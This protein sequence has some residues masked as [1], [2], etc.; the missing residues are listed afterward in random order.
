MS[1]IFVHEGSLAHT[2]SELN[3]IL[4]ALSQLNPSVQRVQSQFVHLIHISETLTK[5]ELEVVKTLLTYGSATVQSPQCPRR[6]TIVPRLGTI[7][8]WSS[9]ATDVFKLCNLNKVQRV[10]RGVRWYLDT[11]SPEYCQLLHDRMTE[12]VLV[13]EQFDQV[14]EVQ[15]AKSVHIIGLSDDPHNTLAKFNVQLGLALSDDEIDY[16]V[17]VFNSLDRDPTDVELM[18]FAQ[19]NSEHCRHKIFNSRW[20]IDGVPQESSLFQSIRRT[21]EV[22]EHRGVLSAY[23][24]NAAV[25]EGVIDYR[26][27]PNPTD[28][29]YGLTKGLVDILMKVETHN[30]PTSISPWAGAATG[31][32]GEIRDEGAVGAGSKPKAGLV[33][34]TTSHLRIP[35]DPQPWESTLQHPDRIASALEIMLEGPIGAAGYNNEYGRPALTGYFRTFEQSISPGVSWGYHKPIMIAG[36][37]GSVFREHIHGDRSI[38]GAALVVLGGSAMLIGL[39]GGSSSSMSLGQSA[40]DLDFASVQRDNA[41]LERRCQEVIDRCTAFQSSNPIALIHDVGAG[42]LSNAIPELLQDIEQGGQINL[43]DIPTADF[44]MSPLEIWCNEAQERYVLA[45]HPDRLRVFEQICMRERCPYAVVGFSDS[46]RSIRVLSKASTRPPIDLDLEVVFGKPPRMHREF[47]R[48][49]RCIE[50]AVLDAFSIDDAIAR[51]LRF[52]AVGSKKFLV[53]IGDRSITGLIAQEQMV[54]PYQIPVA[55][56][57]VTIAGFSTYCGEAMAMGERPSIAPVNPS[58]S[59]RMAIAEALTNL[60]SVKFDSLDRVVLSANWMAAPGFR[61]EDEALYDAVNAAAELCQSLSIAIPVGKDSL[62]MKSRWYEQD[63]SIEVV[64][65]VSLIVSAF[66]PVHDVRQRRTPRLCGV[67]TLLVLISLSEEN[68]IGGSALAQVYSHIGLDNPDV[69]CSE[70]LKKLLEL[71][72]VLHEHDWLLSIHDRSDGGLFTTVLEMA[73]AG[74]V[75]VELCVDKTWEV[76]LFSEE[77]GIVVEI[78]RSKQAILKDWCDQASLVSRVI[79]QTRSDGNFLIKQSDS[80]VHESSISE[81]ERIWSR[82]SYL[83][84]RLR[85]NSD[86]A[87]SEFDLIGESDPGLAESLAFTTQQEPSIPTVLTH[88]P[89]VAILRDQGVNGQLE[90]AA[91]FDLAGFECVDVHMTDLFEERKRLVDFQILAVC[92]GFS[93]GDVLGAG[94]GWA[95]SILFNESL[96]EHFRQFFERED[97][98]SLGICNGCQMLS[99][100]R[101]IIPG[102]ANWPTYVHNQSERFEARTVQVQVELTNSPWLNHMASSQIPIPVAHGEG[103]AQCSTS[104]H[105]N[106]TEKQ[107]I[108]LR[109]VDGYGNSTN[110]YPL[111]PNGSTDAIA[112]VV[113]ED[114]RV[115]IMMPHPERVFRTIQNSWTDPAKSRLEFGPWMQLFHNARKLF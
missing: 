1:I 51:V 25:I 23:E 5:S 37:V 75:G 94:G 89:V 55:D 16:L 61:N 76:E 104:E 33:G 74:R 26:Y 36:G 58:A 103:R 84:Q 44:G 2:K 13:D 80:I 19:A 73:I 108:A 90:M 69:N 85:D 56:A 81:L 96:R 101:T 79:G 66:A 40:E 67:N 15:S 42:G 78:P 88:Q 107:Q 54:G 99:Q 47:K 14:F 62:S 18:M 11:W 45:I 50:P 4:Q 65:P 8:P 77:V 97:S 110:R 27:L 92:G 111:N 93:Y 48:R 10:E 53:T 106:L 38:D 9:K 34:Y 60:V 72:L 112:G 68:R 52:P 41:E 114:G 29:R 113:S 24:D 105:R 46:S 39:G 28:Q 49:D 57:A 91:A 30:H 59:V 70:T 63:Q 31:S 22:I 83:M 100:L 20:T 21:T 32:G 3:A 95:K 87:E 7:S 109:Y 64:S 98:L 35:D 43:Q 102:S 115:L 17:D 86:C 82:T 6:V 12:S 71:V